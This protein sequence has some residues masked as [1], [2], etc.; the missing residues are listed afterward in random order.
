M[1]KKWTH[2]SL[3]CQTLGAFYGSKQAPT[4]LV[5][6]DKFILLIRDFETGKTCIYP[7]TGCSN[8]K[9]LPVVLAICILKD[10]PDVDI[11]IDTP[12]DAVGA[13]SDVA[14]DLIDTENF[15]SV[16]DTLP[17][18]RKSARLML[19]QSSVGA[20][21]E[22]GKKTFTG[23]DVSNTCTTADSSNIITSDNLSADGIG[24]LT[25]GN[26][27]KHNHICNRSKMN[28]TELPMSKFCKI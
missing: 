8:V 22:K 19:K 15:K 14:T 26:L 20:G 12:E 25:S 5:S 16:G 13:L 28:I 4:F 7:S 23:A 24:T 9:N 27:L 1:D 17:P 18:K 21:T 10:F 11:D 3:T 6:Q 2:G